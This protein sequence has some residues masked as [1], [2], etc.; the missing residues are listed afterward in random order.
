MRTTI[1]TSLLTLACL[2]SPSIAQKAPDITPPSNPVMTA[3]FLSG[4]PDLRFRL[5]G[6]REFKKQNY[7]E[8]LQSFQRA[9]Y[10]ADKPSQGMVAEMLWNGQGTQQDRALAYAWMDLAAERGYLP[11]LAKRE[12]YWSALSE[13][14]RIR[15][16]SEGQAIHGRYRDSVAQP[17]LDIVL[18]RE[19]RKV[20]GSRTG[21]VGSV[22]IYVPGPDG[23]FEQIDAS[24]FYDPKYW[25]PKQYRAWHDAIWMKPRIGLVRVGE[26]EKVKDDEAVPSRVPATTPQTNAPEP[27]TPEKDETGLGTGKPA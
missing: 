10:Y 7:E 16:V 22:Q 24:K 17:R 27:R 21:F 14:E 15:A 9:A 13:Q 25:D 5:M 26:V 11:F 4:H 3:G 8:A 19:R 2:A 1:Q 20:T 23:E 12:E 6:L 18:R